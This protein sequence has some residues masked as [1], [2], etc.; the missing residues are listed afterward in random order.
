[1][2]TAPLLPS[3]PDDVPVIADFAGLQPDDGMFPTDRFRAALD[4]TLAS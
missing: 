1:M 3:V 2:R 4:E